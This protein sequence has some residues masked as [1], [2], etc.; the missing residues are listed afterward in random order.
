MRV[1]RRT[2]EYENEWLAVVAKDV[3]RGGRPFYG[4]ATRPYVAI[5]A[6]TADRRIPLVRVWRPVVET[7]SVELPSGG[8]EAGETAEET[9]RR[10]LLEETGC[11]AGALELVGR[12]F[13]DTGRME[14][15]QSLFF[16]PDVAVVQEPDPGPE[17]ELETLFVTPAE[18]RELVVRGEL[19]SA[20][21]LGAIGHAIALGYVDWL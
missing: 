5:L 2:V 15:V 20:A 8:G 1:V 13:V 10:E 7:L 16:A 11:A 12:L 6:I 21:H 18:L 14:T 17:E 9:A 19:A 4:V 3:D